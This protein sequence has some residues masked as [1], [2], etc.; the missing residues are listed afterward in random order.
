MTLLQFSPATDKV[1][2][3]LYDTALVF[4]YLLNRPVL[5]IS[6]QRKLAAIFSLDCRILL[7]WI[8][9]AQDRNLSQA[10]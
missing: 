6:I 5:A 3:E 10:K 1:K 4:D 7:H 2:P 8:R 9:I